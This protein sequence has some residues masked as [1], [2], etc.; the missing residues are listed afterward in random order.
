VVMMYG[1]TSAPAGWLFCVGQVVS[2]TT[3]A[4]LYSAIGSAFN[5]GGEGAGNFRLPDT[6]GITVRG[7]GSQTIGAKTYTGTLGT[8]QND[9]TAINGISMAS[10]G[11]HFH[12]ILWNTILG[13]SAKN[14]QVVTNVANTQYVNS[15]LP[16]TT[17]II[18][19]AGTH[20]HTL[21]GDSETRAAN[22]SMNYI[23]KY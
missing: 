22:V 14:G 19:N 12:Q 10:A 5:T 8:Y 17:N 9:T 16:D 13:G 15:G 7:N 21:T 11:D 23:I 3:Y 18:A 4:N 1:G 20:T 6:R 2:Q